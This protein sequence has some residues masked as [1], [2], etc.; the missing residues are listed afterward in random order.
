MIHR[1][2]GPNSNNWGTV[3]YLK[4]CLNSEGLILSVESDN[5]DGEDLSKREQVFGVIAFG[6][7]DAVTVSMRLRQ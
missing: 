5:R 6:V 7:T 1:N 4:S 3:P 2:S